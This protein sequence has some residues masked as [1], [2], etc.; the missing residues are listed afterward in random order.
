MKKTYLYLCS[1]TLA[2]T[3]QAAFAGNDDRALREGSLSLREVTGVVAARNP[4]IKAAEAKWQAMKARVPQAAAW[5]DL[6]LRGESVAAR[7]VNINPN[8]FTDQTLAL[9]QELPL[10]GKNRSRARAATAD[11]G[12]AFEDLRRTQLDVIARARAA[13]YRLANEYA[14]LEVNRR[15]AGLLDQFADLSQAR[16]EVGNARQAEIL[17]ARTDSARLDDV[18]A[19]ILRRISDAQTELNV[20][21]N[22][23]AQAPLGTPAA[24]TFAEIP[25]SLGTLQRV[26]LEAR[27]EMQRARNRIEAEKARVQ[28]ARRQRLPDPSFNVKAGRYNDTGQAVSELDVGLSIGLPFLNP[29][30]YSAGITEA[31]RNLEAAQQEFDAT[32]NETLGLVRDQ[33]K[34]I[35]TAARHYE[36]CRDKI[37]PLASQ[38]LKSQ[39]VAYEASSSNFLEL[40][41]AER[42]LQDIESNTL[43]YLAEYRIG[44]AELDA[45]IGLGDAT[46]RPNLNGKERSE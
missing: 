9:E 2:L 19:D 37:L 38:T 13:Y 28:L 36:L 15:N 45:I 27:P 46:A 16:Y 21:M 22:R 6:R 34:K 41:G 40:I 33:L 25:H 44:L 26:A 4:S 32:R 8:G 17:T 23:P 1:L 39:R 3:L 31:E 5:E 12:E 24:L 30:K 18:Q 43:N 10:S 42:V 11:A 7:F 20:L 35:E 29:R 14:Q